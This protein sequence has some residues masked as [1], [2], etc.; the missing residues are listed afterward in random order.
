[1]PS[2]EKTQRNKKILNDYQ[3]RKFGYKRLAQKF[4]LHYTTVANIIVREK[5]RAVQK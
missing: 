2:P 3:P 1:M 4:G 5:E